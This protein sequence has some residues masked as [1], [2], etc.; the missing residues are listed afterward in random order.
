MADRALREQLRIA[1]E[2]RPAAAT[3]LLLGQPAVAGI[4]DPARMAIVHP[5]DLAATP[6]GELDHVRRTT[7]TRE[8]LVAQHRRG[9]WIHLQPNRSSAAV[10]A[11]LEELAACIRTDGDPRS[12]G[13]GADHVEPSSDRCEAPLENLGC[14]GLSFLGCRCFALGGAA[15][16]DAAPLRPS[17]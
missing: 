13:L 2:A 14:H 15:P 11:D 6:I 9:R 7:P 10:E 4:A 1:D 16:A 12:A 5:D 3:S 17:P 8:R